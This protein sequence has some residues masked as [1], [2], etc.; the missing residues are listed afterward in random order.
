[1]RPQGIQAV[2]AGGKTSQA[3][4]GQAKNQIRMQMRLRVLDQP[5]QIGFRPVVVLAARNTLLHLAIE[6][7]DAHF[8]LQHA[9]RELGDHLFQRLR[10]MIGHHFEMHE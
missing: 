6:A 4:A 1:V 5:A 10:Q 9:G 8:E 3:F 7:L 2:E